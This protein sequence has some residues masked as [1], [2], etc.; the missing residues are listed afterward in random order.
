MIGAL[1]EF[2]SETRT[3]S[4][5]MKAPFVSGG[6]VKAPKKSWNLASR[7]EK[8]VQKCFVLKQITASY[9]I[10]SL[11]F[12]KV[13]MCLLPAGRNP[14]DF[15]W[16]WMIIV[17]V[18]ITH[19]FTFKLASFVY[20]LSIKSL[21]GKRQASWLF[22]KKVMMMNAEQTDF[23]RPRQG[24]LATLKRAITY[25]RTTILTL[26]Y[27]T[28]LTIERYKGDNATTKITPGL[29]DKQQFLSCLI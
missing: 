5:A 28:L 16:I 4:Q 24:T 22:F 8:K 3:A 12:Y 15:T 27:L 10:E 9:H 29:F 6:L 13:S 14:L 1:P 11:M 26:H 18:V 19:W 25:S 17:Y 20:K 7:N 23:K 2:I 21:K